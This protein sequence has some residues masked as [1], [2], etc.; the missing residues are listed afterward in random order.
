ME[1]IIEKL[2]K[3]RE[4]AD[5]GCE[6]EAVA[7]KKM[8]EKLLAKHGLNIRDIEGEEMSMR[9]IKYRGSWHKKIVLQ[10]V[11]SC[12][13]RE[14]KFYRSSVYKGMI[15]A[16]LTD[17]E[18]AET[19][20]KLDF[21]VKQFRKEKRKAENAFFAAYVHQ[22]GLYGKD[23]GEGKE[24]SHEELAAVLAMMERLE[25]VSYAKGIES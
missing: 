12:C 5:R 14:V 4:L 15:L 17:L 18:Y 21:H 2:K 7:A 20:N 10:T 3:I 13:N 19:L 1:T 11:A 6:G 23:S 9:H 22:H 25:K 8:L 24:M 16:D